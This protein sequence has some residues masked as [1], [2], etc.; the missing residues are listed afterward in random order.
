MR[1]TGTAVRQVTAVVD[2]G[3]SHTVT[4]V[5]GPD[6]E[7]TLVAVAGGPLLSSAVFWARGGRAVVGPEAM[8]LA[9]GEP[10]RLEP[11]PKA[12]MA[13]PELLLGDDVVPTTTLVR[14]VL[15]RAVAEASR[16]AGQ[17]QHLVLTHPV[18]WGGTRVGALLAAAEGLAPRLSTVTEPVAAAAWFAGRHDFPVGASIGVLDFGGGTCDAAVVRREDSGFVVAGCAGLPELGG[19]DLDQRIVEW[20]RERRSGASGADSNHEARAAARLAKEALSSQPQAE[21]AVPGAGAELLTRAEFESLV[22]ADLDRAVALLTDT[23]AACGTE[24]LAVHLVGGASR[25]PLLA[26]LLGAR[27][28]APVSLADGPETVVAQGAQALLSVPRTVPSDAVADVARPPVAAT[29]Q[30][31]RSSLDA[32]V[33]YG[34]ATA[35]VLL[36]VA[37]LVASAVAFGTTVVAGAARLPAGFSPQPFS[38]PLAGD[39]VVGTGTRQRTTVPGLVGRYV[40]DM[41]GDL[42]VRLDSA[43]VVSDAEVPARSGYRW[44]LVK[45]TYTQV[46]AGELTPVFS[47]LQG[48]VDDRG[49]R[50]DPVGDGTT[51]SA[52]G[53]DPASVSDDIAVGQSKVVCST[54]LVPEATPVTGVIIGE[55][56]VLYEDPNALVFPVDIAAHGDPVDRADHTVGDPAV[57]ADNLDGSVELE[58]YDVIENASGYFTEEPP[59]GVR[60][61]LVRV[62]ASPQGTTGFPESDKARFQLMDER[63]VLRPYGFGDDTVAADECPLL[64]DDIIAG[65]SRAFC[66]P[67]AVDA[68]AEVAAVAF[69]RLNE[70]ADALTVWRLPDR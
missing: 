61:V 59:P 1:D 2:F 39:A 33:H 40:D 66:L 13:E 67:F 27:T 9:K 30:R 64:T 4:V 47:G 63:G 26:Q 18:D 44:V 12:R 68:K 57:R 24:L 17:V 8:R 60:F 25:V 65:D 6:L 62:V 42:D 48:L 22:R 11:R 31:G 53:V 23:A 28:R 54:F 51:F 41:S 29:P 19:D 34:L 15:S 32:K 45:V 69:G 20:V 5:A 58:V 21:V 49:Q 43:S 38:A 7:P 55:T 50:L 52:C 46:T 37:G 14:G 3:T 36:V 70:L 56:L 35:V 16:L 10:A